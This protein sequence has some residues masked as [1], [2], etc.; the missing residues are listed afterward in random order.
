M[1]AVSES[2]MGN[3]KAEFNESSDDRNVFVNEWSRTEGFMSRDG[4]KINFRD[5]Q[6][7]ETRTTH[8][9]IDIS[10]G[11]Q[12]EN[13]RDF[14]AAFSSFANTRDPETLSNLRDAANNAADSGPLKVALD[15]A[16]N[17]IMDSTS[18]RQS[19]DDYLSG[20]K[21]IGEYGA[22][23]TIEIDRNGVTEEYE[24]K[25]YSIGDS[26]EVSHN[27]MVQEDSYG[28]DRAYDA[29]GN[30]IDI[31]AFIE[32]R[33]NASEVENDPFASQEM[34]DDAAIEKAIADK[35]LDKFEISSTTTT[36][37][38]ELF[39]NIFEFD[40]TNMTSEE[41]ASKVDEMISVIQDIYTPHESSVESTLS[42]N[43]VFDKSE[44][45]K[46]LREEFKENM[47]GKTE[48]EQE[49]IKDEYNEDV[50]DI[51]KMV[52]MSEERNSYSR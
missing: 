31:D 45:L 14:V 23:D 34:K 3:L 17:A 28:N 9:D 29:N 2:T 32:F 44:Q 25:S 40:P 22:G 13:V 51:D 21:H 49:A 50:R 15:T 43:D 18:S 42:D 16:V 8:I 7:E 39:E 5:I 20:E 52:V 1:G 41:I 37:S 12:I 10:K 38:N 48:E 19:V 26:S 36:E 35:Y 24:I 47:E 11:E 33:Q 46:E 30:S 27:F 4:E 6:G